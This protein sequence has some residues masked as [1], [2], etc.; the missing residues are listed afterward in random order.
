MKKLE[1]ILECFLDYLTIERGL[2][3]NTI[4][5]YRYDLIKYINFLKKNKIS[6]FNQTKKDLVNNY[7]VFLRKKNLEIN[8]ISRNLVAVKMLYRF[9]L[10]EGFIKEDITGLIE[11]PRMSKKLPH[12]LSLREI[13]LL[14]DQANFKSNLGLRDQAILELLYATGMRVSELIY[15]KIE[16]I[17]MENRML[18]CLGKGSKER[19]IPFGSKAD[20]S[21]RL[22]LDKVRPKLVKNPNEDILFLNSRGERLSRQG[23]FYLVKKYVRKAGI[24]KKVTPHTLRHTLATH[25]LENGADLRSVQEMLGHS[26]ISTTQIYT[27]VSRKW[28]SE[29]YYR[30]FPRT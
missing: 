6:S 17:N 10:I 27:H 12:V 14:L 15:L 3:Q 28:V 18:K 21:L 22:Y 5:S 16:D 9:L 8:S 23:I 26:D 30:A 2:A 19:I 7:F 4:I 25:L 1:E 20:E 11:F 24:E 29:E 13:N